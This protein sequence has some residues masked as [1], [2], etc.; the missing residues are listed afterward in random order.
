MIL[1]IPYRHYF[2]RLLLTSLFR[3]LLLLLLNASLLL[4]CWVLGIFLTCLIFYS[5]KPKVGAK[6]AVE[7]L[8]GR[9]QTPEQ[10]EAHTA[11]YSAR[12]ANPMVVAE[13][14]F[15]DD[16][17]DPAETR[18]RLCRDLHVLRNKHLGDATHVLRKKHTNMPL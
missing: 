17:L 13:R 16:I 4:K 9:N 8:Y 14:G 12:F 3:S 6:G 5:N 2:F 10:H 18:R 1:R 7:I 15:I 11:E